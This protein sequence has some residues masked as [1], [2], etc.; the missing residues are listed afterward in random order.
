MTLRDLVEKYDGEATF[1]VSRMVPGGTEDI[2]EF[3]NDCHEAIKDEIMACPVAKYSATT[4]STRATII[5]VVLE[6]LPEE[7][8]EEPNGEES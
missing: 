8:P 2:I 7:Q 1:A 3:A 6:E 4:S 5:S